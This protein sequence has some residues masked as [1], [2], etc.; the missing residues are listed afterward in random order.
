MKKTTEE[1]RI[2]EIKALKKERA[3]NNARIK[4]ELVARGEISNTRKTPNQN[5][6]HQQM[7]QMEREINEKLA[8]I[9]SII[10]YQSQPNST[11]PNGISLAENLM[12]DASELLK[13]R[14]EV[15]EIQDAI[16]MLAG[17][18]KTQNAPKILDPQPYIQKLAHVEAVTC[19]QAR[20]PY[21]ATPHQY[22]QTPPQVLM[23]NGQIDNKEIDKART[24]IA[25]IKDA[26]N[27]L[28]HA[29]SSY[30][31]GKMH[32]TVDSI[33]HKNNSFHPSQTQIPQHFPQ[34]PIFIQT[35]SHPQHAQQPVFVHVQPL[36]Q[37][38]NQPISPPT[39]L[40]HQVQPVYPPNN[41]QIPETHSPS[42]FQPENPQTS[43]L[44]EMLAKMS[45]KL[46]SLTED[47]K[48]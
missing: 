32:G 10:K 25:E 4:A 20:V 23:Q 18:L 21:N 38:G 43:G 19:C 33:S 14:Y 35:P 24:E 7:A 8:H 47:M 2:A 9:E 3:H 16:Q 44:T 15:S 46:D 17:F 36:Q 34:Q 42:S 6:V 41:M 13:V 22:V 1:Q 5:T 37:P 28:A 40:H 31:M 29:F 45:T 26:V 12:P 48:D 11:P 30:N 39:Q 27:S